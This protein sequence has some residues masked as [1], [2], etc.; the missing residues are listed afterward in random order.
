MMRKFFAICLFCLLVSGMYAQYVP[1]VLGDDYLR[2]TIRM[3]DD[4]EGKVVCTLVKKPQ[5]PDTRQAVLYIHGYNDYFFQKQLG[6]SINAHGYN[7]YAMDLR[8]YGRSILP[9]QNPF[10]C[11]SLTEYFADL[12]TALAIIRQEGNEK[13]VLMAH[14]TGG[15]ITPYY[16]N[17]KKGRLPVDGL[18]LNSPFLDW[19]F[20][21]LMEKVLIPTVSFIGRFFPNLTVQGYGDASYAHSLLKQFKGEWEYNTDWKMINGHPK[22]AGWIRAIQE[23]QRTVQ[24]GVQ[25]DCPVLVMSSDKSF[26]ETNK[27]NNEYL[28][29]DI[30]L[31][32]QDIQ[33][34]GIKL[35]NL[36]TRD[37]IQN[38]IH[39]LILSEKPSRD[40]VYHT[41]FD[42]L[43]DK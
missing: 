34:Y 7:F 37:T 21:W 4:Y 3:P 35:G 27:W 31:N 36:V 25:L 8:K 33:K 18:I 16:L 20:G 40:H 30:V 15:L 24:K 17:S 39:D 41:V 32:V 11:K 1:D 10:F 43:I 13:I 42:W 19:N 38:G 28:T 22:K 9:N 12:D 6:D 5:L 23:A 26:P 29:S 2:R 14:S